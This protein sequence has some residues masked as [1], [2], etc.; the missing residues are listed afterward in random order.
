MKLATVYQSMMMYFKPR[1]IEPI[2]TGDGDN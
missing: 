1:K 2:A